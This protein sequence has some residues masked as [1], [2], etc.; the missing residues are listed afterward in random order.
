MPPRT[1][2][3][4]RERA[5]AWWK[6][7]V[8]SDRYVVPSAELPAPAV[9]RLLRAD[10]LVLEVANRRAWILTEPDRTDDRG[11]FL[12][13]Y[14]LVV[15]ELLRRWAPAAVLGIPAVQLHLGETAPPE[16]LPTIHSANTSR[17]AIGCS[18]SSVCTSDQVRS[19]RHRSST[20]RR[21]VPPSAS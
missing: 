14:W 21:R 15:A 5:L 12:R 1:R 13:N 17:Y 2:T 20:C 9:A 7:R 6:E 3:T 10:R 11:I 16:V 18:T 4:P 8:D 19:R